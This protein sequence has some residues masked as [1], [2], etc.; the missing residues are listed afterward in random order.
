MTRVQARC[1]NV[2]GIPFTALA[3]GCLRP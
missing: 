1:C 3:R 2:L